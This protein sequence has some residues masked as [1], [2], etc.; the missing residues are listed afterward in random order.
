MDRVP[1]LRQLTKT[2]HLKCLN[3]KT[4]YWISHC[5]I[6]MATRHNHIWFLGHTT[7]NTNS[8]TYSLILV[9]NCKSLKKTSYTNCCFSVPKKSEISGDKH[10]TEMS[11]KRHEPALR[12]NK[13]VRAQQ[14]SYKAN[15]RAN[16]TTMTKSHLLHQPSQTKTVLSFQQ[17]RGWFKTNQILNGLQMHWVMHSLPWTQSWSWRGY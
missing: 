13:T 10:V 14:L 8:N 5:T 9:G 6:V 12:L 3:H 15:A 1:G 2:T 7:H 4:R 16:Y 11:Q 17:G